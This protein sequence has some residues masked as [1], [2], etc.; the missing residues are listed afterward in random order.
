LPMFGFA[1]VHTVS[2]VG[3][4]VIVLQVVAVQP[5][6]AVAA[7]GVHEPTGVDGVVTVLHVVVT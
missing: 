6:A 5:F 2:S 1:I 4:V 7:A 3:P